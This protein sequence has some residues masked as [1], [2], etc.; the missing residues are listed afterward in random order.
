MQNVSFTRKGDKLIIELD[1]SEATLK[2]AQPSASGKS[3]VIG[4]THGNQNVEGVV[5]GVN[6]YKPISKTAKAA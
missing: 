2:A 1:I 5:V 4:S 6:C 3:L